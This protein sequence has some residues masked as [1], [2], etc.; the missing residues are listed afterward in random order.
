LNAFDE[1]NEVEWP[2]LEAMLERTKRL[3]VGG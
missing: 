2:N 3:Q 1:M